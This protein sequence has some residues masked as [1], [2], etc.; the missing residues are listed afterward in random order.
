MTA[1]ENARANN[2]RIL[3]V[4]LLAICLTVLFNVLLDRTVIE[5]RQYMKKSLLAYVVWL[6]SSVA[7]WADK[8]NHVWLGPLKVAL[9]FLFSIKV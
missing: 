5:S 3:C 7:S 1:L 8:H 4:Y 6:M 2:A 9:D